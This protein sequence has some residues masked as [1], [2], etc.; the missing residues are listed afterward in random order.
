MH[1]V[2]DVL[3]PSDPRPEAR[4]AL[5]DWLSLQRALA[6][7]PQDAIRLLR[8]AGGPR[9]AL[10]LASLAR[11]SE[12]E[13]DAAVAALRRAAAVAVP[14][15]SPRY[16]ERLARLSDAAPLLLVRG[17]VAA[18]AARSSPPAPPQAR[19]AEPWRTRLDPASASQV[20]AWTSRAFR[21]R[22][23]GPSFADLAFLAFEFVRA[24][25]APW[26]PPTR[27]PN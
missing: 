5:R 20:F 10:A 19:S 14:F 8:H 12:G 6:L 16:P 18:L 3:D 11:A 17:D 25:V 23:V 1:P 21:L 2:F 26:L 4:A 22:S 27:L 9:A 15:G 24:P 7:H 13:L